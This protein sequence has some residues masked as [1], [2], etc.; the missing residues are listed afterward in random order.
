MLQHRG[1]LTTSCRVKEAKNKANYYMAPL[2]GGT[3]RG[4]VQSDRE[5]LLLKGPRLKGDLRWMAVM[6]TPHC[7]F[8]TGQNSEFYGL[9]ILPQLKIIN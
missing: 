2:P 7:S 6:A 9:C 1:S 4:Q 5:F 3:S 8:Q